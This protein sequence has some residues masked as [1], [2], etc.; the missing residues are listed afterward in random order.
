[1]ATVPRKRPTKTKKTRKSS[2]SS[3][4]AKTFSGKRIV[5]VDDHPLIRRGLERM[6]HT[7]DRFSVCGEAGTAADAMA[8]M[9]KERPDLAIVDVGLPY[10]NGIELTRKL[11]KEFPDLAILILSMH[12]EPDYA[13][14]ALE[15]GARG[16]MVKHDAVEKIHVALNDVL[17]GRRYLSPTM[18]AQLG[19]NGR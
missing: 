10:K 8:V 7:T 9:R 2:S 18:K 11:R 17:A 16:Y 1:M 4:R 19:K 15:A 13:R 14:R 6:I 3:G 5:I 12:E